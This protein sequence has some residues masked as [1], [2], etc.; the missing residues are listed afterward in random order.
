MR[1]KLEIETLRKAYIKVARLKNCAR[2]KLLAEDANVRHI[3]G[4]CGKSFRLVGV[5]ELRDELTSY[6]KASNKKY[7]DWR[8]FNRKG[9]AKKIDTSLLSPK[10]TAIHIKEICGIK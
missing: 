2:E 7:G 1:T 9:P 4:L 6:A 10:G 3:R 5:E 8:A